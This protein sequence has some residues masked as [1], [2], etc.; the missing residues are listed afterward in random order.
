MLAA[1]RGKAPLQGRGSAAAQS[2][3]GR[4]VVPAT[5]AGLPARAAL[6]S[7][8]SSSWGQSQTLPYS[9]QGGVG[10]APLPRVPCSLCDGGIEAAAAP[11]SSAMEEGGAPARRLAPLLP[12]PS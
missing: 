12:D 6:P 9:Q 7:S 10:A 11:L 3:Q 5:N 1:C 2:L 8:L 4:H